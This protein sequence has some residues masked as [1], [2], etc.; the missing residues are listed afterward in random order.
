MSK[1]PII[2]SQV[3]KLERSFH[4]DPL[5]RVIVHAQI[6]VSNEASNDIVLN[7]FVVHLSYAREQQ[8]NNVAQLRQYIKSK[9][10]IMMLMGYSSD[11]DS[12]KMLYTS[13]VYLYIVHASVCKLISEYRLLSIFHI[14]LEVSI[15][16]TYKS[17][18][19]IVF[20]CPEIITN[21]F[22]FPS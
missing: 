7:V 20:N 14:S 21:E 5:T 19:S 13:W 2:T 15:M 10:N 22:Y 1:Y 6:R 16:N 3:I 9:W 17:M 12:K 4:E 8:C 11:L 18:Y